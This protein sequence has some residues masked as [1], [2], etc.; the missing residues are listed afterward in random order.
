M[1]G[2]TLGNMNAKDL[3]NLENKLEKGISKI[4]SKKVKVLTTTSWFLQY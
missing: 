2:E 1:M 3:R 4:R